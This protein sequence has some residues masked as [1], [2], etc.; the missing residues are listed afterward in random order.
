MANT[1]SNYG[2]IKP[3]E[4]EYYDIGVFNANVDTIDNQLK[5]NENSINGLKRE[6]RLKIPVSVWSLTGEFFVAEISASEIKASD[7]PI[8]FAVLDNI[9]TAREVKEY[10]KNYAFIHRGETLD[11]LVRFYAY[12]KPNVDLSIGLRG[13]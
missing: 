5:E 13:K 12:K 6:L 11:G 10:N 9:V 3:V 8:M 1:T 4:E 2:L 7:N